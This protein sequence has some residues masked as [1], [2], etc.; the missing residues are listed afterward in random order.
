MG[1]TVWGVEVYSEGLG[2][3]FEFLFG[4][5]DEKQRRLL[6]RGI[7]RLIG[8]GRPTVVAEVAGMTRNTVIAGAKAFHAK[9]MP[10]GRVR[11]EGGGRPRLEDVPSGDSQ[12]R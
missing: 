9:E 12:D 3:F 1:R 5:L 7:A 6:A 2:G 8:R 4:H 11:A 10:T